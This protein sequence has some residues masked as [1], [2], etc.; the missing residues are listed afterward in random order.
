MLRKSL[1]FY[2]HVSSYIDTKNACLYN[3]KKFKRLI[4]K[5]IP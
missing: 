1:F 4:K 3:M 2:V 5:E